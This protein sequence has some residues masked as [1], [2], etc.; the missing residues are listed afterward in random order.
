MPTAVLIPILVLVVIF[1]FLLCATVG[2]AL[3]ERRPIQPYYIPD[4]GNEYEPSATARHANA[5]AIERG[6]RHD[7]LCHDGKGKLYRVRYDFWVSP[8]ALTFAVVG[9]GTVASIPVNGIW[10]Y[11]RNT[12]GR[13]LCTTNEIGEQDI[14]GVEDQVTWPHSD[15]AAL[16]E[17]HSQRLTE[18]VAQPFND[19]SALRE[20]FDM[21]RSKADGLV[22]R[23]Y[24]YYLNDERLVWRYTLRGDL[25][26]YVIGTWVRPL[27]R[28]LR[29][30][31]LVRS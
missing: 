27:T 22:E 31:G 7:C 19:D 23:G 25:T 30:T 6:F 28:V 2:A 16:V 26:L 13:I 15:F 17:K 1:G 3:W 4:E 10:L 18:I 11:S 12:N 29:S 5:Q 8:D 9:S 24:A 14:S 21:R 20:F